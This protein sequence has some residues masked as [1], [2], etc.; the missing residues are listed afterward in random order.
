MLPFNFLDPFKGSFEKWINNNNYGGEIQNYVQEMISKSIT[1]SMKSNELKESMSIFEEKERK[2]ER[3]QESSLNISTFE[4]L[5]HVYVKIFI[6]D[7]N[8]LSDLKIFHTTNQFIVEGIPSS[9]DR[10]VIALPSIVKMKGASSEYRDDYLQ[11]RMMKKID[12]QYTE[13]DVHGIE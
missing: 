2:Q 4:T 8:Q 3:K 5:D 11:I 10:H 13:I 7:R 1:S 12:L 6:K 9:D